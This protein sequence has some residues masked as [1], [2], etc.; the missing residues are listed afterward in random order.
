MLA[1]A[2]Q[3]LRTLPEF[4]PKVT[5]PVGH[6]GKLQVA[7]LG[8]LTLAQLARVFAAADLSL[9]PVV[10]P[11]ALGLV[12]MEALSAGALPIASYHSGLMSVLDVVA[13]SLADPAFRALARAGSPTAAIADAVVDI[14]E[15]YPVADPA[16]RPR[17]HNLSAEH[18]AS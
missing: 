4:G 1:L 12:T 11:E 8:H 9:A 7:F 6:V 15:R 14:L 5:E 3:E 16:F 18:F 13:D 2:E 10:F 17:L